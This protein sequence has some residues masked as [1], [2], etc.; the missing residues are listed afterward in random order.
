MDLKK[1][2][3]DIV[4]LR[5]YHQGGVEQ[6]DRILKDIEILSLSTPKKRSS[7]RREGIKSYENYLMS[8]RF[9]NQNE[10]TTKTMKS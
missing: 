9:L 6:C 8:G 4:V 3:Q 5:N 2:K 1:L 7:K 10:V